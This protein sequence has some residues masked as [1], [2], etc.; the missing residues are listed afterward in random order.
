MATRIIRGPSFIK[1]HLIPVSKY[2][3]KSVRAWK[4]GQPDTMLVSLPTDVA[5]ASI[6]SSDPTIISVANLG[7][8]KWRLA[9]LTVGRTNVS[10]N[11]QST[12]LDFLTLAVDINVI[13]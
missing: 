8:G 9:A 3:L 7:G 11:I 5:S 6:T 10:V 13:S 2:W 12:D 1:Y 4:L